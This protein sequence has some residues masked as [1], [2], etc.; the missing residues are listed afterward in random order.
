[1]KIS[2]VNKRAYHDFEVGSSL[3]CGIVLTGEDIKKIRKGKFHIS[4]NY[5]FINNGELFLKIENNE[6]KLLA[7]K[8]QIRHLNEWISQKGYTLI[9]VKLFENVSGLFK[10]DLRLAKGKKNFD[11]RNSLK[12][13]D[14]DKEQQWKIKN[15]QE[16]NF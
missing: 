9:A 8:K 13:K 14:L 7:T 16:K 2:I 3:I 1:M 11:K 4:G 6:Y 10:I 15:Y 12:E 5:C